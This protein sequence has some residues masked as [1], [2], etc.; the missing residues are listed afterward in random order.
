MLTTGHSHL[1]KLQRKPLQHR[2]SEISTLTSHHQHLADSASMLRRSFRV[3]WGPN[4]T[5]C[6]IGRNG[7]KGEAGSHSVYTTSAH[8]GKMGKNST[9]LISEVASED[10]NETNLVS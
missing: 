8:N 10:R 4:W 7:T 6:H 2:S 1:E 9:V 3:G 5:L